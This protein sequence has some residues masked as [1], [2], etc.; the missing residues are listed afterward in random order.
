M[1]WHSFSLLN[2]PMLLHTFNLKSLI[3]VEDL[4]LY[5]T[6]GS[7]FFILHHTWLDCMPNLRKCMFNCV[8]STPLWF[9]L[10]FIMMHPFL[11]CIWNIYVNVCPKMCL[12]I[13]LL[14]CVVF[15]NLSLNCCC[16]FQKCLFHVMLG[17]FHHLRQSL[18]LRRCFR[19]SEELNLMELLFEAARFLTFY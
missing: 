8:V 17:I 12:D 5:M 2:V 15:F 4:L 7:K 19:L 3:S 11:L 14:Y 6:N 18:I 16:F 13:D 9:V 10:S 1:Q